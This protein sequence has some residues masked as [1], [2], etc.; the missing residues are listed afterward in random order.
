MRRGK[1]LL[2]NVHTIKGN[3]RSV[4]LLNLS[5][6]IHELENNINKWRSKDGTFTKESQGNIENEL[7][8][9]VIIDLNK[10]I[11]MANEVFSIQLI[12]ESGERDVLSGEIISLGKK[13]EENQYIEVHNSIFNN[14]KN[15]LE[16]LFSKFKDKEIQSLQNLLLKVDLTPI[17]LIFKSFEDT[18][19]EITSGMEKDVHYSYKTDDVYL[20]EKQFQLI[21]DSLNHILRNSLDHG[22]E[23]FDTR[24][25][26]KKE[27]FG[28]INIACQNKEGGFEVIIKDDGKGIDRERLV[29]KA[30][31]KNL[32]T[33]AEVEK[34]SDQEKLNLIFS[35]GLST[36][37]DVT[38][39]SFAVELEWMLL[40][41]ILSL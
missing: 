14:L 6:S 2:R 16:R 24:E 10:Y 34:L 41:R 36:K 7:K 11:K 28:K 13:A 25:K 33:I 3:A 27:K 9:I 29:K 23:D 22:I 19:K 4:G 21:N 32:M 37:D 40:E 8:S 15:T 17:V 1:R 31:E 18:I 26:L 35:S 12:Q 39:V 30:L 20:N 38:D 5:K